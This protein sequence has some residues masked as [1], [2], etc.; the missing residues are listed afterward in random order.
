MIAKIDILQ[1]SHSTDLCRCASEKPACLLCVVAHHHKLV[2]ELG[3]HRFNSLAELFVSP[4]WW[5]PVLLIEPIWNLKC[6]VGHIEK[7][8]LNRCAKVAFVAEHQAVVVFPFGIL[9]IMYVVNIGSGHVVGMYD[10]AYS[11]D[12]VKFISIIIHLLGCAESF[13]RRSRVIV[14]S[15]RA[16]VGSSHLADFDRLGVYHKNIF[17]TVYLIGN[18][19]SDVFRKA[20]REFAA[21]IELS[22]RN[23]VWYFLDRIVEPFE[24][25]IFAVKSKCLCRERQS[26]YL[27]IGERGHHS[28]SAD[29]AMVIYT[30]TCKM[31]ADVKNFTEF[32]DEVVHTMFRN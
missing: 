2:I 12:S 22:P 31:L 1:N 4:R 19:L 32:Y 24:K 27:Q 28:A 9:K 13:G 17:A 20:G 11:A 15:H 30:I 18:I 7:V 6:D 5:S 21:C 26:N 10:S 23:K 25:H 16:P 29:I 8:L 3:E 14:G